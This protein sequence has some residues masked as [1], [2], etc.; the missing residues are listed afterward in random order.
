M[1]VRASRLTDSK[2]SMKKTVKPSLPRF[3]SQDSITSR[4]HGQAN[5]AGPRGVGSEPS[6]QGELCVHCTS[7]ER[8]RRS[9]RGSTHPFVWDRST[10][11]RERETKRRL[12]F[13][14]DTTMW[15]MWKSF[16]CTIGVWKHRTLHFLGPFSSC[17]APEK[18]L[19]HDH[20][21][22]GHDAR[23]QGDLLRMWL[24]GWLMERLSFG[25]IWDSL[26]DSWLV[27]RP[28]ANDFIEVK[29]P[30]L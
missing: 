1:A 7:R 23:G 5:V 21:R 18:P 22:Q 29:V 19:T 16:F 17:R 13:G 3:F 28:M 6:R 15:K 30:V 24:V 9:P 20:G 11:E 27:L 12:R 25:L 14:A 2:S 8:D 4:C 10:R 26:R